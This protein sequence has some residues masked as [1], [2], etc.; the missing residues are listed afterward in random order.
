VTS[1]DTKPVRWHSVSS[2]TTRPK[3]F[4]RPRNRRP[5]IL[6][7]A[8]AALLAALSG[9]GAGATAPRTAAT[10]DTVPPYYAETIAIL[11]PLT[12]IR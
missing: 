12:T 8:T 6:L 2:T 5:R 3:Q 7:S 4:V 11:P 10:S 1:P 9:C